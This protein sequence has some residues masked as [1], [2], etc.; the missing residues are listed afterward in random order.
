MGKWFLLYEPL[1]LFLLPTS[2]LPVIN[3]II[4]FALQEPDG[5]PSEEEESSSSEDEREWRAELKKQR[6][7][8]KTNEEKR[9]P[10]RPKFY[11]LKSGENFKT[12]KS[13]KTASASKQ[14][15]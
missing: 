15:K 3:W 7:E 2:A 12:V 4:G 6:R 1:N 13:A 9:V 10:S 5:R 8:A 11:E 14:K